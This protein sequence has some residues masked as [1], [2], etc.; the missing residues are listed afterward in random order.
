MRWAWLF[1]LLL[2]AC[3]SEAPAFPSEMGFISVDPEPLAPATGHMFY[4]L[5]SADS[6]P[7]K[8]P[9]FVF[10]NGGPGVPTSTNLLVDATGPE[11]F[12]VDAAGQGAIV[13][14]A[15]S[16]TKLGSLLYIDERQTGFSYDDA[17][18]Y[19][20][21]F[22]M[23]QDAIDFTRT[24]LRVLDTHPQLTASRVVLVGE[25]YGG[26]RAQLILQDLLHYTQVPEITTEVQQHLDTVFAAKAVH[27]PD[28]VAHQF[29]AQVLIQPVVVGAFQKVRPRP[30]SDVCTTDTRLSFSDCSNFYTRLLEALADPVQ[31]AKLLGG[32]LEDVAEF[33]GPARHGARCT[34]MLGA[35][36]TAFNAALLQR[37]GPLDPGDGYYGLNGN[38][39]SWETDT[40][41]VPAAFVDNLSYVR[42]LITNATYDGIVDTTQIPPA[43]VAYGVPATLD[44][45]PRSGIA[46]PGWIDVTLPGAGSATVRLPTYPAGHMVTA[47]DASDLRTDTKA[48]LGL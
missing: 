45:V 16:F 6:D 47:T 25:S 40:T 35:E 21:T 34:G 23:H 1:A 30:P 18:G 20:C 36:D 48:W 32:R 37:F 5:L 4:V 13:E 12:I 43:L 26:V 46:R 19:P 9:V 11:Q 8:K 10:F 15:A 41:V 3:G 38:S 39:G 42:T 27:P 33:S 22:D 7:G 44:Q 17:P 31:S 14:N 24:I 28:E 29:F 2:P